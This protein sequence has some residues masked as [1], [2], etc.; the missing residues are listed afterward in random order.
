MKIDSS[1][2]WKQYIDNYPD[3]QG[4][5]STQ[6]D[7][8]KHWIRFGKNKERR[9]DKKI[10]KLE[11]Q[12]DPEPQLLKMTEYNEEEIIIVYY[13]YINPHKNW[14]SIVL[15]QINDVKNI[16]LF[17]C[18]KF[19]CVICTP[20]IRLFNECKKIINESKIIYT[21]ELVNN[22]E[23][24]GIK[25]LHELGTLYPEKILFY[26]HSKGMVF[27]STNDRNLHEMNI[28]VNTIKNWK[29]II[30]I[31]KKYPFI[32]KAG[33]FPDISGIIW[34]NFFWIRGSFL[35]D[36]NP[37][38]IST[39]RYYY[40]H[41]FIANKYDQNNCFN[42]LKYDLSKVNNY[43]ASCS[44][45]S[46]IYIKKYFDSKKYILKYNDLSHLTNSQPYK[47]FISTGINEDRVL[48]N[49]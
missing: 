16:G 23:Y 45:L 12:E 48:F 21:H 35:K 31:F 22:F 44:K 39:D 4:V 27:H 38:I 42:L 18:C 37:P 41:K 9:T 5:L 11:E 47:H 13:I 25:K 17:D 40:E 20:E 28:L 46:N 30:R 26:M 49:E 29:Y 8:W 43:E 34:F 10:E 2:N 36:L 7:A 6:E 32:D 33:L 15:G 14:K 3:L 19:F 1:F 24:P